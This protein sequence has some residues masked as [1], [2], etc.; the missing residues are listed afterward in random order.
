MD[1]GRTELLIIAQK[2]AAGA[3]A[4]VCR[5]AHSHMEADHTGLCQQ[6]M[7]CACV[8]ASDLCLMITTFLFFV[9]CTIATLQF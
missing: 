1:C 5:N 8:R 9:K 4:S 3:E 7:C 6:L 2:G